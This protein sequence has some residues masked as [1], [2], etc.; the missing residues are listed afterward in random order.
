MWDKLC[1]IVDAV[2][3]HDE[4]FAKKVFQQVL[5]EIYRTLGS[6]EIKYDVPLRSSLAQVINAIEQFSREKSGGD[7][8]LAMTAALFQMIGKY[9]K[10][11]EPSVR[12]G[13]ITASDE[14]LGYVADIECCDSKGKIVVAIEVKDRTV[15]VSDL[16]EKLGTTREKGIKEV[17]FVSGRGSREAEGVPERAA[18]EFAAGQNL[19]VFTLVELAGAILALAGEEARKDF[20]I[21]VG[22]QLDAH[23]DTKHRLAW[24]K[25]LQEMA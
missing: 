23:S 13:K 21:N 4:E 19:Y 15:T 24:K 3:A 9:F 12:R 16:E 11:F 10:I 17:F 5:L 6:T 18:K 14:S 1:D 22:Q 7:R 2:E 20:L 25:A 8:P